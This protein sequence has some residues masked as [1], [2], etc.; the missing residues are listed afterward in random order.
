MHVLLYSCNFNFDA[1]LIPIFYYTCMQYCVHVYSYNGL[2][3]FSS[4]PN[5]P[6]IVEVVNFTEGTISLEWSKP[7]G[8][9]DG[10]NVTYGLDTCWSVVTNLRNVTLSSLLYGAVYHISLWSQSHGVSSG[11][12]WS[13]YQQTSMY[14]SVSL[15]R[16]PLLFLR[17]FPYFL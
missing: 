12:A 15:S 10:Y 9:V 3:S 5:L 16:S 8:R 13:T 11:D 14:L 6:D 2:S 17:L 7:R 4:G 1:F